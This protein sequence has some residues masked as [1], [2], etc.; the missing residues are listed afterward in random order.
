MPHV[1]RASIITSSVVAP[2]KACRSESAALRSCFMQQRDFVHS[3]P[4]HGQF[5]A[6]F[7]RTPSSTFQAPLQALKHT[8]KR[9]LKGPKLPK[10]QLRPASLKPFRRGDPARLVCQPKQA[11]CT[12]TVYAS[13]LRS[14][15]SGLR[16][17]ARK[18]CIRAGQHVRAP[19]TA[20]ASSTS[21]SAVPCGA[22]YTSTCW[23]PSGVRAW[24][25]VLATVPPRAVCKLSQARRFSKHAY[26]DM[27]HT[28]SYMRTHACSHACAHVHKYLHAHTRPCM[29]STHARSHT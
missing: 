5:H 17:A 23:L 20:I 7:Q 9:P 25:E 15:V 21:V 11:A 24:D 8:L 12:H 6:R 22:L 13:S 26:T 2:F 4:C 29:H 19:F 28:V 14:D 3:L 16:A 27:Q 10:S 1:A 18:S